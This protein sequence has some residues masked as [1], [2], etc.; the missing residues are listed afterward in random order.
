MGLRQ[1]KMTLDR[2]SKDDEFIDR[3]TYTLPSLKESLPDCQDYYYR[4]AAFKQFD[5][6]VKVK[7]RHFGVAVSFLG[8]LNFSVVDYCTRA[9]NYIIQDS[10]KRPDCYTNFAY[11]IIKFWWVMLLLMEKAQNNADKFNSVINTVV[12]RIGAVEIKDLKEVHNV[13]GIYIM[14][15]DRYRVCYVGQAMDSIKTRI[16]QHWSRKDYFT[17]WGIDLFKAYDTTRIYVVPKDKMVSAMEYDIVANISEMYSLNVLAGGT[18]D[19]HVANGHDFELAG[20]KSEKDS[21]YI[22]YTDATLCYEELVNLVKNKFVVKSE[23]TN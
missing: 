2:Y 6:N 4:I 19:Y 11:L 9:L 7:G 20:S 23:K 12:E 16:M 17:G 1:I 13:P 14:V 15:L 22:M 5:P 8:S 18:V 10:C 21:N 3:G